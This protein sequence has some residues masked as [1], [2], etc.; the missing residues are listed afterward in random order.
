MEAAPTCALPGPRTLYV[1]V[2]MSQ[3]AGP[4]P[5]VSCTGQAPGPAEPLKWQGIIS[6]SSILLGGIPLKGFYS[7]VTGSNE[8]EL[9]NSTD[10][11]LPGFWHL[12]KWNSGLLVP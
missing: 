12:L 6:V 7:K 3:M 5:L 4:A 11:G 9:Q 1:P 8:L 10:L 2:L